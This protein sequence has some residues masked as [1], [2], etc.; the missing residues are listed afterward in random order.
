M[1]DTALLDR[2]SRVVD[3]EPQDRCSGDNLHRRAFQIGHDDRASGLMLADVFGHRIEASAST[4]DDLDLD[5]LLTLT[6]DVDLLD[7]CVELDD[8]QLFRLQNRPDVGDLSHELLSHVLRH[9]ARDI[10]EEE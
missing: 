10:H 3:A 2:L 9:G 6:P 5:V 1:D 4:T 8:V 7:P